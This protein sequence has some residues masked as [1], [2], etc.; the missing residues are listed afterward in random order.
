MLLQQLGDLPPGTGQVRHRGRP[1][2]PVHAPGL[3]VRGRRQRH[4][5]RAGDR[6]GGELLDRRR[7]GGVLKT[8][9]L[10]AGR[11]PER[12]RE[13]HGAEDQASRLEA[14][15]GRGRMGGGGRE[16]L[17][18]GGHEGQARRVH[19]QRRR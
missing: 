10:S 7:R 8:P 6:P 12:L 18:H 3:L 11:R 13:L 17:G 16:V 5:G 2:R 4:V 14:A 9:L 19:P 15:G 1:G